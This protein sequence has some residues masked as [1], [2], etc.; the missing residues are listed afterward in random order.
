MFQQLCQSKTCNNSEIILPCLFH[1]RG[2]WCFEDY[3]VVSN[4]LLASLNRLFTAVLL[5]V[6]LIS[7]QEIPHN[8]SNS[9]LKTQLEHSK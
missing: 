3:R 7:C 6:L 9:I 2:M 4:Q 5:V 8:N 1:Y